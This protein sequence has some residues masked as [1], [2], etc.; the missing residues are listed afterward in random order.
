MTD[1]ETKLCG[2]LDEAI[3]WFQYPIAVQK[4]NEQLMR[5]LQEARTKWVN[6]IA[7]RELRRIQN[8]EHT[9]S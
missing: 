6:E 7:L 8:G 9:R 3:H 5:G 2:L 4:T 1:A